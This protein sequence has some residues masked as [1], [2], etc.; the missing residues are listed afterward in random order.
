MGRLTLPHLGGAG[1][2]AHRQVAKAA[3]AI[4]FRDV[5]AQHVGQSLTGVGVPQ[6]HRPGG[7]GAAGRRAGHGRDLIQQIRLPGAAPA[8]DGAHHGHQGAGICQ[9][10][11]L[12]HA[13]PAHLAVIFADNV[14]PGDGVDAADAAAIQQPGL[15]RVAGEGAPSQL[16]GQLGKNAVAGV[17]HGSV[18]VHIPVDIGAGDGV[19]AD[20]D[21]A[22]AVEGA[23]CHTLQL[24]QG[25]SRSDHLK[26]GAGGKGGGKETVQIYAVILRV[27]IP[28]LRG[29][30]GVKAGGGHHAKDFTGLVVVYTDG[31]LGTVQGLI[32]C[33]LQSAVQGQIHSPAA[34]GGAGEQGVA[35]E[36]LLKALQGGGGDVPL[37]VPY[38]VQGGPAESVVITVCPLGRIVQHNAAAVQNLS[39]DRYATI[40]CAQISGEGGPA[41]AQ[42]HIAHGIQDQPRHKQD[43]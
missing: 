26:N 33:R 11:V 15:L 23:V 30:C 4:G 27:P 36:L 34:A 20:G 7:A 5:V 21:A 31:T 25:G 35:D 17:C 38:G 9:I 39:Q 1:F 8:G 2:G 6:V 22:A 43:Q 16:H 41:A 24:F 29:L 37:P 32:G 12:A 14:G 10:L 28:D 13:G 19:A 40:I 18:K 42:S 3:L